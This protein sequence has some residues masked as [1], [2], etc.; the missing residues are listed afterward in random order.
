YF[1]VVFIR[2]KG[3]IIRFF[4]MHRYWR[5]IVEIQQILLVNRLVKSVFLFDDCQLLRIFVLVEHHPCRIAGQNVKQKK[6]HSYHA[7]HRDL[8]ISYFIDN[9][10]NQFYNFSLSTSFQCFLS[11]ITPYSITTTPGLARTMVFNVVAS[12][13]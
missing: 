11:L 3:I 4:T 2:K 9:I 10:S 6:H 5:N 13:K 12:Q 7:K 1:S 8:S